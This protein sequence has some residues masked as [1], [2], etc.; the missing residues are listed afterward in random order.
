M[1]YPYECRNCNRFF[2]RVCRLAEYEA[3]PDAD[4]P[5]CGQIATQIITP[6]RILSTRQFEAFVSPVD[7]STITN[8][9]ELAEHNKRNNVVNLHDGYDEAAVQSFT[10]RQLNAEIEK[11][12][13]KDLNKDMEIAIQ[14]LQDGYTPTPAPY[15][16]EIPDA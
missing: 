14:K 4:C 2:E 10:K 15:T 11:E 1:I 16:E 6:P 7:G 8:H 13:Q 12:R 9:R 5:D 3:D